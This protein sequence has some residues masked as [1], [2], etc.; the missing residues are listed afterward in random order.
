MS[1]H[2]VD[3]MVIFCGYRDMIKGL[4]NNQRGLYR[5]FNWVYNIE[6]YT[7]KELAT[8]FMSKLPS[9]IQTE[10]TAVTIEPLFKEHLSI[11]QNSAGDIVNLCTYTEIEM[12]YANDETMTLKHIEQGIKILTEKKTA[13][14]GSDPHKDNSSHM[15]L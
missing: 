3:Q 5:R 13:Q 1:E 14:D 4:Y 7:P 15:Y 6:D 2:P 10:L 9:Q 11:F 12:D 8:I